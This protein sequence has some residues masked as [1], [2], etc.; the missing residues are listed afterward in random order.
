MDAQQHHTI[1]SKDL[2]ADLT[3]VGDRVRHHKERVVVT[4]YGKPA[5]AIVSTDDLE[6][7]DRLDAE[8]DADDASY[9]AGRRSGEGEYVSI[10]DLQEALDGL[11]R[12]EAG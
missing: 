7:L 1:S 6:L 9:V 4:V 8:D 10:A 12:K 2:R 3:R 11:E 5:Y